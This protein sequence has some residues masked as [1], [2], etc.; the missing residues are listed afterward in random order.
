M[1]QIRKF[2]RFLAEDRLRCI[3]AFGIPIGAAA[4]IMAD[5]PLPVL[6]VLLVSSACERLSF[7]RHLRLCA[8]AGNPQRAAVV[9]SAAT[10]VLR[11]AMLTAL[12]G[13]RFPAGIAVLLAPLAFLIAPLP[14]AG[15]F[16][17]Q[18]RMCEIVYPATRRELDSGFLALLRPQILASP[19]AE[20]FCI[21][22]VVSTASL[23]LALSGIVAASLTIGISLR[24]LRS[25]AV[26]RLRKS[27]LEEV[28]G[29]LVEIAPD[30][31]FYHSGPPDSLYQYRMWAPVLERV[32]PVTLVVFRETGYLADI[33]PTALPTIFIRHVHHLY[34]L[35]PES[36][37]VVLYAANGTSNINMLRWHQPAEHV[38]INHG[39][40]DK[41]V[42]A[43]YFLTVYSRLFVAGR[44]AIDR[45]A[46]AF[47][48]IP[49]DRFVIVG[50]PQ[51]DCLAERTPGP[52]TL[53]YAPTWEGWN[54]RENYCSLET[55][56]IALISALLE[57]HPDWKIVFKPHPFTGK[58]RPA[59]AAA[60]RR[61]EAM[62]RE[63]GGHAVAGGNEEILPLLAAADVLVT[64]VSSVANDF[65]ATGRPLVMADPHA[66]GEAE[67]RSRFPTAKAAWVLTQAAGN[68]DET[69]ADALGEDSLKSARLAAFDH[70]L[71]G[72][73]GDSTRTFAAALE[74]LCAAVAASRASRT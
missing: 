31:L 15:L 35:L 23:S 58:H 13:N 46:A 25:P 70:S 49:A 37:K 1:G 71:G 51:V 10:Q 54:P 3:A 30:L 29:R 47:F 43:S 57:R 64:D 38:F 66:L 48:E 41:S 65:L 26:A 6:G 36:A 61:I 28:A 67:F 4:A 55:T 24:F 5:G 8:G 27:H 7:W 73:R 56:G 9:F 62:L 20:W 42:N 34:R 21:G 22:A 19:L 44:Q 50:R 45:L 11:L 60:A 39:E 12:A 16:L 53:L 32:P 17:Q 52:R 33:P 63:R 14:L 72:F 74:E 68:L 69:L 18:R 2:A 59:A 40:S